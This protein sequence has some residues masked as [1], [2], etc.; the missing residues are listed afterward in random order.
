MVWLLDGVLWK[1]AVQRQVGTG[2]IK[3]FF[4]YMIL[5]LTCLCCWL[6][7]I[8]TN[9]DCECEFSTM[10]GDPKIWVVSLNTSILW[11]YLAF[12]ACSGDMLWD[13]SLPQ[14]CCSYIF[15]N[16]PIYSYIFLN[17]PYIHKYSYIL[18]YTPKY[19]LYSRIFLFI[20][21]YSYNIF[22]IFTN[23]PKYP[24]IFRNFRIYS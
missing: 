11:K 7:K 20:P 2:I 16:I 18:L 8:Y 12:M 15:T 3:Q 23:I 24:Y 1:Q 9:A 19:F 21:K 17:I 4:C 10:I 13:F 6:F 5:M 14:H 22:L